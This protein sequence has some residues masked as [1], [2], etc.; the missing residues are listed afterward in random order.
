MNNS[1]PQHQVGPQQGS[2]S[3]RQ[4]AILKA[5]IVT[6]ALA[7]AGAGS[8]QAVVAPDRSSPVSG[9]EYR[10]P[11]LYF[12]AAYQRLSEL[13]AAD[14]VRARAD[15]SVLGIDA[16]QARL[17][18]RGG[19]WGTLILARP[20][21]PGK[22]RSNQLRW[23]QLGLA[24]PADRKALEQAA[25]QA[26]ADYLAANQTALAIRFG[27]LSPEHRVTVH[28]DGEL[29]QIH[30]PR[31][32]AGVPVRSSYLTA[33]IRYGNLVLLGAHGWGDVAVS[34]TPGLNAVEATAA[35][36]DFLLPIETGEPWDKPRLVLIPM[37]RGHQPEKVTVGE[38]YD[39]RLAWALRP[40]L[41]GESGRWEMLVDAHSGEVL[42][43]E[44]TVH[45][46][47][48]RRETGGVYPLSNDG[49][50]A[51]GTEQAGWPM[52]FDYLNYTGSRIAAD[53]GGNLPLC[54]DGDV[55]SSI[56]GKYAVVW[57]NGCG[58]ITLTS[59]GDLDY[60]TST[61]TD[62]STP[63]V[64]DV[65]NTHAARTGYYELNRIMEQARGQ[66][67]AN[68]WLQAQLRFLV[69]RTGTTCQATWDG[70]WVNF[71]QSDTSCANTGE[72]AGVIDHEFGHGLDD[73]DAN[74]FV[75]NPGEGI[76]DLYAYLRT[77]ASCIGRGFLLGSQC[78][79]Y[80]DA[81]TACD[82]VRDIDYTARTSAAPHDVTW[83]DANCGSGGSTPCGGTTHCEG[84]VYAEAVYELINTDLP[85]LFAMDHNTALEVG[86]RLTYVAAGAVGA[87][88][89]C[90]TPDGGCGSDGGYLNFLAVDDDNGDLTDGTPHMS[91]IFAAF[92]RQEIA[93]SSPAVVDSGCAGTPASAPVVGATALDRGASLSWGAVAGATEYQI[94]RAEG[95]SACAY[96]KTKVGETTG[97]SFDDD[98]LQNG[99]VYYYVVIPIGADDT[100]FGPASS[101]TT[102]TPTAG[103]NLAFDDSSV[104]MSITTGDGDDF[105]DNCESATVT[106]DL[107][108]IGTGSQTDV[109]IVDVTSPTHPSITFSTSFPATISA[110]LAECDTGSGSFDLD[111]D[112]LS[113]GDTVELAIE[114]TSDEMTQSKTE[115]Y[116]FYN[117]ESDFQTYA[118]RTFT[119]ESDVE[120]WEVIEGTFDR[121]NSDGGA[122]ST[123]YALASSS[124]LT[125]QCDVVR[126]PLIQLS[127]T[128]TLEV[129]TEFDI[130]DLCVFP[131]C[132]PSQWYDRASV[133]IY[134]P[135]VDGRST[136]SPDGGRAYNASGWNG[137]CGT[138]GLPGWAGSALIWA[139]SSWTASAL[140][141]ATFAGLDIQLDIRYGTDWLWE[142][143]GFLFDQVTVT[144]ADIEDA[145][146]Q[147]DVCGGPF[148]FGDADGDS[149]PNS[150]DLCRGDDPSLDGDGD[151]ICADVD[152]DDGD[153]SVAFRDSCGVCGGDNSSCGG[154]PLTLDLATVAL[155]HLDG[156]GTDAGGFGYD[157]S[158][159]PDRVTWI[160]G[161][162]SQAAEMGT[163]PWTG[164]CFSS[165]GGALTAPGHGITY[166]G[167]G[168]WMIEAWIK[169]DDYDLE[170]TVLSHYSEH[171]EVHDPYRLHLMPGGELRFTIIDG[172]DQTDTLSAQLSAAAGGWVNVAVIYR[173][174]Q[175][176]EIYEDFVLVAQKATGLVPETLN[177]YDGY[178]GGTYCGTSDGLAIDEVR[179][180]DF[181]RY[182][183]CLIDPVA[184]D[185]DGDGTCDA[186]DLC[187]GFDDAADDDGDD[188]ADGCDVCEGS[189]D[190]LD[191]DAD[192]VPDGCDVCEGSDDNLDI[193]A[194]GVP[195][196]CDAC[197]GVE[198]L[199]L[200][201]ETV[202]ST[203]VYEACN[204]IT[205]GAGFQI[206]TPGDVTLRA[207]NVVGLSSGF[208]VGAGASLKVEIA[209]P[210]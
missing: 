143:A 4:R 15:L 202:T 60:G 192:G 185:G 26:L 59:A 87:W 98:G 175:S 57:G 174:G 102:V 161:K 164:D 44:D 172:N 154:A 116:F 123:A 54:A 31:M 73:N 7:A 12:R 23:S 92:D 64:G 197:I 82:G 117:A 141:S 10:H 163:D 88:F 176:L 146:T 144:D 17:D 173:Y 1:K 171:W 53:S 13:P 139:S 41:E 56:N 200:S 181:P 47:T 6:L 36:R 83:I 145:D 30:V 78:G 137:T 103:A 142:G 45:H 148:S 42:A 3:L 124:L 127:S 190:N 119:F 28:D 208:S 74:L 50:G 147:S 66:L 135:S 203:V 105:L 48:T 107:E 183:G 191:A 11:D 63:G 76:A 77:D 93:C 96:G 122:Q 89:Q 120:D 152:C 24:P 5:F 114:V 8:L 52:P 126:S 205:A 201:G 95:V 193:D 97:T 153:P 94:F 67:P 204:S 108:N 182:Q 75:S 206:L 140:T 180:S 166:P 27:E 51:D 35:A 29:V 151:G 157:L 178:V 19:R 34:P 131:F 194:D 130:E 170:H 40:Q 118:T 9:K 133:G 90:T 129:H 111:A 101:C 210:E 136:V 128:S 72:L 109:R 38:G 69:N 156:D 112:G 81:C 149:V 188:V 80:G 138:T 84:A 179:I 104:S 209:P 198:D 207:S 2:A 22:G 49:V 195:D 196:G 65:G 46:A 61:G 121:T 199:A 186:F 158:V 100:C 21:I 159:K 32:V 85:G 25:W 33:V 43:F 14:A 169:V 86:T 113:V 68:L 165:D 79:G 58:L 55:S 155:W 110:S 115:S 125:D 162:F 39:Y 167:A 99:R 177:Q 150:I 189:D 106:F 62:C 187:P 71:Y 91:A 16:G 160:P 132:W 134:L 184:D 18:R 37:A 20:L 70:S 168:D